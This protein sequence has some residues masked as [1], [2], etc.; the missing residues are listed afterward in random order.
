[1]WVSGYNV[2]GF[3]SDNEPLESDTWEGARDYLL[4]ELERTDFDDPTLAAQVDA[5][6]AC[7]QSPSIGGRERSTAPVNGYLYWIKRALDD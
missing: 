6:I 1:M 4:W 5:A 2:S 7:L 3:M